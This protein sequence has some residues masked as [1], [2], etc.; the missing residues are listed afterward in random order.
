MANGHGGARAG[1]GRPQ[2]G[3]SDVRRRL[4]RGIERGLAAAAREAGIPGGTDEELVTGA[5]ADIAYGMIRAGR[6]PEVVALYAQLAARGDGQD[7]GSSPLAAALDRLPGM[8]AGTGSAHGAVGSAAQPAESM[9]YDGIATHCEGV[10]PAGRLPVGPS[11]PLLDRDG[12]PLV[13]SADRAGAG[14]ST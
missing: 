7:G 10:A 8:V 11:L 6:G 3:I 2:G 1:A 14:G 4:V 13:T 5:V 9:D 12:R